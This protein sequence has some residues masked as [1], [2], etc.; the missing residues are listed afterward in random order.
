MAFSI[1]LL[2]LHVRNHGRVIGNNRKS[3]IYKELNIQEISE[4]VPPLVRQCGGILFDI[5][6]HLLFF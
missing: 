1:W 2:V 3:E 6:D 5:L 4:R